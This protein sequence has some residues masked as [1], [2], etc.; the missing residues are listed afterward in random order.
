M[1]DNKQS[2]FTVKP[3]MDT[4]DLDRQVDKLRQKLS[5]LSQNDLMTNKAKTMFGDSSPMGQ[6]AQKAF[7]REESIA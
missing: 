6:G 4:S 2:T 7:Q 3:F 5:K 1:V